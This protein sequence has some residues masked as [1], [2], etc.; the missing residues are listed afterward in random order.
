MPAPVTVGNL[1][2]PKANRTRTCSLHAYSKRKALA[3]VSRHNVVHTVGTKRAVKVLS[4][5][6]Q[7]VT[8]THLLEEGGALTEETG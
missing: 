1:H 5:G 8:A 2:Q 7:Q 6:K 4:A 3:W